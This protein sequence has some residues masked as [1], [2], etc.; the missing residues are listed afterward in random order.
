MWSYSENQSTPFDPT[1]VVFQ[2]TGSFY[3][4]IAD[5]C[6]LASIK[7]HPCLREIPMVSRTE[8]IR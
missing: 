8:A 6:A 3:K 5:Y 1:A 7:V 2:P 4:D